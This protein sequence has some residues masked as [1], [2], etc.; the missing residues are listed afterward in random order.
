MKG[1]G[2]SV[3]MSWRYTLAMDSLQET[4]LPMSLQETVFV[5]TK[6]LVDLANALPKFQPHG[7][8]KEWA[9]GFQ[10]PANEGLPQMK[11]LDQL[12]NYRRLAH[13]NVGGYQHVDELDAELD[14][15]MEQIVK[16]DLLLEMEM[17]G[18]VERR[19]DEVA[20]KVAYKGN[21]PKGL[22]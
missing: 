6:K 1:F 4:G 16:R 18:G 10:K 15:P 11:S 20:G 19:M 8:R 7:L 12:P 17:V 14:G 3:V 21:L 2:Y 13:Q 9:M 22:G 5:K